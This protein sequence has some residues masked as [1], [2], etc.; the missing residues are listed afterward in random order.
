MLSYIYML[1][2]NWSFTECFCLEVPRGKVDILIDHFRG[3]ALIATCLAVS[4]G[5]TRTY[6]HRYLSTY[7]STYISI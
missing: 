5:V 6:T 2:S 7:L 1:T 3:N 4:W